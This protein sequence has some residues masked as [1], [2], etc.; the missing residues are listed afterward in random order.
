VKFFAYLFCVFLLTACQKKDNTVADPAQVKIAITS[1]V[2]GQILH[3]N[4]TLY[5]NSQVSYASELHGYEVMVL[6]TVSGFVLYD[7]V[8]HTHTDHFVIGD[9]W[10]VSVT[11]VTT[12]KLVVIANIDH[13]GLNARKELTIVVQP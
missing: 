1:P 5:I 10:L 4:D 13:N 2:Q 11:K 9:K 3:N 6:D 7:E 8:Q 12:L